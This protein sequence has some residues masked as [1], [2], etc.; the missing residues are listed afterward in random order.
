MSAWRASIAASAVAAVVALIRI[1]MAYMTPA[2][3]KAIVFSG[4]G[5]C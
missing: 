3:Q 2:L 4:F 5:L 1:A